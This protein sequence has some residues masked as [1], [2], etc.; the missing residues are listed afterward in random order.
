M[1]LLSGSLVG[2]SLGL[3]GGGGSILA[4]PLLVYVVG[5]QDPHLA[6]GTS[7]LAVAANATGGLYQHARHAHVRWSVVGVFAAAGVFGAWLGS[8]LGKTVDGQHLLLLFALLM[9]LVAGLMLRHRHYPGRDQAEWNGRTLRRLSLTGLAVGGMAGFFGIGGGFLIV[10]SLMYAAGLPILL[11]IG[12][13]LL[14]VT[15]FGLTTAI[16]YARA[17]WIDWPLAL[18]FILGGLAGSRLGSAVARRL[19]LSRG[20]LNTIF[21][22]VIAMV[23][24]YMLYRERA[25]FD[26]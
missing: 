3:I 4:L 10:P 8:S 26:I 22:G 23:A 15:A 14:A 17:G 6:I 24:A 1:A 7:A 19:S 16:N 12:S 20:R 11:A 5:V 21:A 2:F 9:L 18:L 13:S 25:L